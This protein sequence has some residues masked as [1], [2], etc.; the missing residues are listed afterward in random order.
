MSF[1]ASTTLAV[2][3]IDL[4]DEVIAARTIDEDFV[5]SF[6]FSFTTSGVPLEEF[7]ETRFAGSAT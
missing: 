5:V 3:S 2:P 4:G 1:A 6:V 7:R